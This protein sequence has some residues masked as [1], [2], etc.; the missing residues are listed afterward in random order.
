MIR[1]LAAAAILLGASSAQAHAMLED[2]SPAVGSRVAAPSQVRLTFDS[3]IVPA[4]SAV[5]VQGP[6]GFGGVAS[7]GAPNTYTLVVSLKGP[8]PA[9]RYHVRWRVTSSLDHHVNEGDFAFE[10][11]P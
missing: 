9:G 11:R 8:V 4:A 2:A 1:F 3:N 6:S 7:V 10:V 5:S